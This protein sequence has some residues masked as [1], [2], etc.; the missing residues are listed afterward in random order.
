M[1]RHSGIRVIPFLVSGFF[2]L[3]AHGAYAQAGRALA[4]ALIVSGKQTTNSLS[5]VINQTAHPGVVEQYGNLPLSFEA[6][7]GQTNS[8]VRFLSRGSGYTLFLTSNEAVLALS[9]P[10]AKKAPT[11]D[12]KLQHSNGTAALRMELVGANPSASITGLEQLPGRSNYFIGN[13][14]TKWRT[15]VPTY[16]KVA[17]QGIYPGTDLVYY[18]NQ[19]QLEYDFVVA[20]GADPRKIRLRIEGARNL[21]LDS[22]SNLVL[23]TGGGQVLLHTPEIYQEF[24]GKRQS[25]GGSWGLGKRHEVGFQIGEYDRTKS[26]VI[27]PVLVYSTYLG[28][29]SFDL[30]TGIAV[31]SSGNAYVVG[32][33]K[34]PNF[35]TENAFQA[36]LEGGEN[37]FVTKFNAAGDTLAYSTYLGG[38]RFDRANS[39]GVDATGNAYVAGETD[40]RDFP[41]E[42]A[43][44]ADLKGTVNAFLTKISA[45]G[46]A[47][48][49]ST[50][51]GGRGVDDATGVAVDPSG[52]AHLTGATSSPD[53]PVANALQ[54]TCGG[55]CGRNAFVTEFNAAGSELVYSTYLGG[56]L[57]DEASGVAVDVQGN[58][59]VTG[60]TTSP[61]FPTVNAFQPSLKGSLNV[62]VAKINSEGSELVFSTYLGGSGNDDGRG[63]A[64]DTSGNAYVVGFTHSSDFPLI[65]PFQST[66]AQQG[67][68]FIAK[69]N[70]CG[71]SLAYSTYLGGSVIDGAQGVAVDTSGDAYVTGWTHSIDFPTANA[72][73]PNCG[74]DCLDNAFI[75]EFNSAGDA[76]IYSSY[77]GGSG[78]DFGEAIAV[79]S[80]GEAFVTGYTN[81]V[82]F[83]TLSPFQS[84]LAGFQN[85]FVTKI[86][87]NSVSQAKPTNSNANASSIAAHQH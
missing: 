25:I 51:L 37:A 27:D 61:N 70:A 68:A 81:S 18:G 43:F 46:N 73:Q 83:P 20:P 75:T 14:P 17:Y 34:S 22:H 35:P 38:S 64:V 26:L 3:P 62:F 33:T 57:S 36:V 8:R 21:K 79:D 2:L 30:A 60:F 55:G 82:D 16:K 44:Q 29:S 80:S 53:F 1:V 69:F 56:N 10:S 71:N 78:Y 4:S 11:S 7:Q 65:N 86:S 45:D 58:T 24:D 42:N 77:L 48:V 28:G 59:Y 9:K 39:I 49:F 76:L 32:F 85:A 50:Y 67:T 5:G 47:L 6:N 52:N 15:D 87:G 41:T 31:D 63:I 54:P 12:R 72:F 13:D 23:L 84:S 19:R 66:F 74:G 40:S